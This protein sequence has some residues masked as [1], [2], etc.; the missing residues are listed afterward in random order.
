MLTEEL[1]LVFYLL[2]EIFIFMVHMW[3]LHLYIHIL[4]KVL[5]NS[6]ELEIGFKIKWM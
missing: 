6:Y 4:F 1:D 5:Q 3:L 2:R